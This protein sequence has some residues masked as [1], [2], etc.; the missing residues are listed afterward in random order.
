[1]TEAETVSPQAELDANRAKAA[2]LLAQPEAEEA[3]SA[4][5][6]EKE[7]PSSDK[8]KEEKPED[9]AEVDRK[10]A[11]SFA[12]IRKQKRQAD[13]ILAVA[14]E[15]LRTAKEQRAQ[16]EKELELASLLRKSADDPS[17]F[18]EAA[19]RA[20][21]PAAQMA[22]FLTQEKEPETQVSRELAETK[23]QLA[24]VTQYLTQKQQEELAL[25][26]Q[27]QQAQVTQA[28]S[29]IGEQFV[30]F[31]VENVEAYPAL[32]TQAEDDIR[33]SAIYWA[34]E[35]YKATGNLPSA[36]RLAT[37]LEHH[38]LQKVSNTLAAKRAQASQQPSQQA[39][40]ANRSSGESLT[41]DDASEASV[42]Q[43]DESREARRRKAIAA[44][45][46]RPLG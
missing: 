16:F 20:G 43:D 31:L 34:R 45:N 15:E 4:D 40:P 39:R 18:F 28:E 32:A 5:V 33:A 46:W 9:E 19:R 14:K 44:L 38:A 22:D 36:E 41:N 27:H 29:R 12:A 7:E 35:E 2:E 37:F 13:Q 6:P 11:G 8:P 26:Q 30:S 21:I 10:L 1:M 25:R 3:E 17:A 23:R 42:T 24:E